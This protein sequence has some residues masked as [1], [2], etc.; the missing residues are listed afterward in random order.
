MS[1][2]PLHCE[3]IT[4]LAQQIRQ[5]SLSP[6]ALTQHFLK[7]IETLNAH[8]KAF[9]LVCADKALADAEAAEQMLQSGQDLGV[10]HGI[11]Y[12]VKDLFDVE[13][14]PTA[15]GTHLLEHNV[16]QQDSAVVDR[17]A[18][19]GMILLGKTNTVQFAYGG[20]GLNHDHGTPYNPWHQTHHVPGGSSSGSAV[21][22]AAGMAPMALGS[23]TGGSVRIPASLCGVVGLKTTVG[24]VSRAGVYPL[25]QTL[26]SVGPVTKTV[27]D[28]AH[29]YQCIHGP[30]PDPFAPTGLQ[31][32]D[33]TSGLID[34]VEGLRLAF[35]ESV[36]WDDLNPEVEK[37]VRAC[38]EVFTGLGAEVTSIE[39]AEASEAMRLN[40]KG[41]VLAAEAYT[42]NRKWVENHFDELDPVVANRLMLGRDVEAV[43]Y[44]QCLKDWRGLREAA[45][46]SLDQ[47]DALLVPATMNPALPLSEI[48]IN[49]D[50]YKRYNF[51]YLRN[52]VIG[53]VLNLCGLVVPCGF[54]RA[55]LPI[56]LMIYGK[57]FSEDMILRVGYAFQEATEW[58]LQTPDL[59]HLGQLN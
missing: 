43:A 8:L 57:P 6:V 41:V 11:P 36:F 17:L 38:A 14:L 5:G 35:A 39:F 29:V 31:V 12:A 24:Q 9:H 30:D 33:V 27:A 21:A 7:R 34:G 42:N 20:V 53:N 2:I 25:S 16:A 45:I 3:S 52:T 54:T 15:A 50:R 48:D 28:A 23:D 19:N 37:G 10:L 59:S 46:A 44:L 18:Q 51:A 26:D 4:S 22:V 1:T 56:G 49:A 55:G 40:P 32:H 58:H 13:G 47:V